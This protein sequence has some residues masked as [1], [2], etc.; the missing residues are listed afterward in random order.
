MFN[1]DAFVASCVAAG[2]ES[3]PRLAIKEI[4]SEA[5]SRPADLAAALPPERARATALHVSDDLTV[6]NV[7]WAPGMSFN[8][9]DHRMWAAIGLYTGGED[10]T[11]FR[12]DGRS[13]V[14]SGGKE[15]RPRDVCLL[16]ADAVHAVSNS[17]REFA[18]AIHVYGGNFFTT[19][20]SE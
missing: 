12:R 14:E 19:S 10:N 3:E 2:G 8:P 6:I 7:V 9:H 16:G 13:L 1:T 5:M 18:G 4:L 20:R 15:L 17:T 11:F